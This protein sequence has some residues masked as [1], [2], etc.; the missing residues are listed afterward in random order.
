M[1]NIAHYKGETEKMPNLQTLGL[2]QLYDPSGQTTDFYTGVYDYA[3]KYIAP[4]DP[5]EETA[6]EKAAGTGHIFPHSLWKDMGNNGL[7]GLNMPIK[8][9]GVDAGFMAA[10]AATGAIARHSGSISLSQLAHVDL[11]MGRIL[12]WGSE[13]QKSEYLPSLISGDMVGALAMSEDEAGTDVLAMK[14]TAI[15]DGSDFIINGSKYWI[16]NGGKAGVIVLYAVTDP[17]A[18]KSKRLSAFLF[19]TDTP[20]FVCEKRIKK[21]GMKRSDT[22]SLVFNDC[23]IPKSAML[24]ERGQGTAILR[25]GLRT[26]RLALASMSIEMAQH[27]YD[28][29]LDYNQKR[30]QFGKPI[31]EN[32]AVKFNYADAK[33]ELESMRGYNYQLAAQYIKNPKSLNDQNS[34]MSFLKAGREGFKIAAESVIYCGGSGF[35]DDFPL[36]QIMCDLPLSRIGGGTENAKKIAISNDLQM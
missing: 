7:L 27:S 22:W 1:R 35:E 17:E 16:T 12:E 2:L 18:S 34:S 19:N 10:I 30:V 24:G 21:G 29:A 13:A 14:T 9:G 28:Y 6:E 31:I 33:A 8:Y 36:M 3:A 32:Q 23:R 26:E 5:V 15:E 25:H 20:G 11:C 4:L